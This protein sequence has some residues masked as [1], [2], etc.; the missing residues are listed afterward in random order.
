MGRMGR[1]GISGA[2]S[3]RLHAPDQEGR[4]DNR[5]LWIVQS[6]LFLWHTVVRCVEHHEIHMK[7]IRKSFDLVVLVSYNVNIG[8]LHPHFNAAVVQEVRCALGRA[9]RLGTI[10]VEK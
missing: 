7:F 3:V 4:V 6:L 5:R 1:G 9:T 2:V 10:V 8:F